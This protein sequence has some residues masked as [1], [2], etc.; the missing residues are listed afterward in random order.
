MT[1]LT[2]QHINIDEKLLQFRTEVEE[3]LESKN[4]ISKK[5]EFLRSKIE[6][7]LDDFIQDNSF[8][9]DRLKELENMDISDDEIGDMLQK[10]KNFLI[11][12]YEIISQRGTKE[13]IKLSKQLNDAPSRELVEKAKQILEKNEHIEKEYIIKPVELKAYLE[14]V[15]LEYGLNDWKIELSE[16]DITLD[17]APNKRIL[18]S[19]N[20]VFPKGDDKRLAVH[21]IGVHTLRCVNG[22]NQPLKNLGLGVPGYLATEEGLAALSEELSG[23]SDYELLR[24][25][26]GRV[27]A[28]NSIIKNYSFTQ[29][30]ELLQSH[31]FNDN[32][33]WT[34][35]VRAHRGGGYIK[36]HVYLKG[37]YEV[38]EFYENGGDLTD[39]YVGKIALEDLKW[40]KEMVDKGFLKKPYILPHLLRK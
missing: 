13:V 6:P 29:T 11:I 33:A 30:F 20:R 8:A 35:S 38:K 14:N 37:Y 10:I 34:L 31:G 12:Q 3:F 24:N 9:K 15:F 25:Y 7:K 40:A 17:D 36:D 2:P 27:I 19:K 16:K 4:L 23:C 26:A 21:E 32:T 28:V 22:L 1:N 39:L 5:E 18:I